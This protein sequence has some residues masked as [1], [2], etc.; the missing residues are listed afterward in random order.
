MA[1][2]TLVDETDKTATTSKTSQFKECRR[3]FSWFRQPLLAAALRS[4]A[5][6]RT[7]PRHQP[8][9]PGP[10]ALWGVL[11]G[12]IFPL[13][14]ARASKERYPHASEVTPG[15]RSV[16][17]Q[18]WLTLLVDT[19]VPMRPKSLFRPAVE[20]LEGRGAPTTLAGAGSEIPSPPSATSE[21]APSPVSVNEGNDPTNA[22]DPTG[23]KTVKGNKYGD[24]EIDQTTGT[25]KGPDG[26][27]LY[28]CTVPIQFVPNRNTVS[29]TVIA[30]V[31]IL[32]VI[33][34]DD[35]S[36]SSANDLRTISSAPWLPCPRGRSLRV[37][38]N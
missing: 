13:T 27:T 31:Q 17:I 11:F 36:I 29:A 24:W 26:K 6:A 7:V 35:E 4:V 3:A 30:F 15:S 19:G 23:L 32:R 16:A 25:R 21:Q 9:L 1:P 33:A 12:P 28:G 34:A 2:R 22:T 14:G 38:P 20:V 8:T 37:S 18:D 10:G 5:P